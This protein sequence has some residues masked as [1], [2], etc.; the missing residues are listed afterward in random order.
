MLSK[1]F[2]LILFHFAILFSC[3]CQKIKI[4]T[5]Y[6]EPLENVEIF[7]APG[8]NSIF[9]NYKGVA[10]LSNFSMEDTLHFYLNG[11][12]PYSSTIDQLIINGLWIFLEQSDLLLPSFV[13][14]TLR[15]GK[16]QL[17]D[18]NL[19]QEIINE[20]KLIELNAPTSADVLKA[21]SSIMIQKSQLGGGSPIIR[22]FE[23]NRVLLVIDGVRMNNAIYRNGHL[24]NSITL[25]NSILNQVDI[26]YGPGS[27]I[28]GSDAIG[29]VVHFQTKDPKLSYGDGVIVEGTTL[30]RYNS[31]NNETT[32]H[33]DVSFGNHKIASLTSIS[34]NNFNDLRMGNNRIHGYNDLDEN[35]HVWG[36]SPFYVERINNIDTML[37]NVDSNVHIGSGYE[38]YSLLEKI[39]YKPSDKV[40]LEVNT[41]Y[42]TTSNIHRYDRL[43]NLNDEGEAEY[44]E[45]YYG[46]QNRFLMALNGEFTN[47]NTFYDRASLI[48]SYQLLDEDRISRPFNNPLRS[49]REEDV[50]VYALNFDMAKTIDSSKQFFYGSEITY[51]TVW[52][53]AYSKN[54]VTNMN[55]PESTRYPDN[56]SNMFT[57]AAYLSYKS[58]IK[59][60]L[61]QS[62]IRYSYSILNANF[63]D[64]TFI[65]LP[66]QKINNNSGALSGSVQIAYN[67][68]KKFHLN[69]DLSSGYRT[70]N[71]DDFGKIFKKDNYVLIPNNKLQSEYA[72][73][74]ELGVVKAFYIKNSDKK[75]HRFLTL[76]GAGY[77]TLLDNAIVRSDYTLNGLDSIWFDGTH[78]KIRTNSNVQSAI[79]YGATSQIQIYF[80]NYISLSSSINYTIGNIVSTQESFGHIPPVFGKTRLLFEKNRWD[81]EFFSEYNGWKKIEDYA[82]GNVDNP[83]EATIDGT[84]SWYTLNIR[85]SIELH[86]LLQLQLAGYNLTDVHYKPFASGISAPGRSLM[87]S[88]RSI[89]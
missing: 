36:Y 78:C 2:L 13:T 18:E 6:Y 56:G 65:H 5:E 76:K 54:I 8:V 75:D 21:S 89:F 15:E 88:I 25:D 44:S 48:V 34:Y 3:F 9:T 82:S 35:G 33:A 16:T 12:I 38:Q 80:S 19:H 20:E 85:M 7:A 57:S 32:A 22:G 61:F 60:F 24:H 30:F 68:S 67:P 31:S 69:L 64:T 17:I 41:Q 72:Y 23:A 43:N 59:K 39:I 53:N 70:P 47:Y 74:G 52:S 83:N 11:Y 50:S 77:I 42:S 73:S 81:I 87:I 79:I 28:Y 51:N 10:D 58:K 4:V 40:K 86:P 63:K 29:G 46:P 71:I 84:P 62:G 45:W 66:F 27:V 55:N 14:T 49:V 1:S 37:V 26:Q